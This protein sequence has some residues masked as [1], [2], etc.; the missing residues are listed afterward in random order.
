MA[1]RKGHREF[2]YIRK[3]PSGRYQASYIAPDL[4]RRKA[5]TTF[6]TKGD[7]EGWLNNRQ[8]EIQGGDWAPPTKQKPITFGEHADR[9]MRTRQLKPRTRDH[10]RRLLER[11]ILPTFGALP[12][13]L[14]TADLVEDWHY[15]LG[16]DKPTQRAHA[17]GLLKAILGDAVQR[18][19][20][21]FNP[22]HIR[23]G[24]NV[25]RARPIRPATVEEL[26]VIAANMPERLRLFVL[27]AGWCGLRFGEL[28]ELRRQDIDLAAGVIRVR[29]AVTRVN[30]EIL[31]GTPKS[32]AGIRDVTIPPHLMTIVKEHL[33]G[34]ITG[35]RDGLLFPGKNGQH[36]AP[37]SLYGK[38]E[39]RDKAGKIIQAGWGF[40]HA[41]EI[42]GRPDLR[43]H[44]LRHTGATL[45][46]ATGA[47][48]AELMARLGHSTVGAALKYQHAAS[49]RDQAIAIALSKIAGASAE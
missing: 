32:D 10:Y 14:V 19:L 45:A 48:L 35:G 15:R 1:G 16:D 4:V 29:R 43:V 6:Q 25:K 27:L 36:L 34:N 18:R 13:K 24:T 42:A 31:V 49:D 17:Y 20:I 21:D 23:G 26:G 47:T 22:A 9:W 37:S 28:I 41:R 11:L 8:R 12:L 46:A 40:Y 44:D 38:I 33:A 3:L 5:L 39:K 7:A 30:G 2:G